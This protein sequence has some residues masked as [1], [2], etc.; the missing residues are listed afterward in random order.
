MQSFFFLWSEK[1]IVLFWYLHFDEGHTPGDDKFGLGFCF[2]TNLH[3]ENTDF[4][5]ES[6]KMI[7][8]HFLLWIQ[9]RKIVIEDQIGEGENTPKELKE[10][11]L[12]F[13]LL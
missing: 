6:I 2:K 3:S 12:N 11:Q 5:V 7:S 9:Q 10:T 1:K 13:S 4:F 8:L